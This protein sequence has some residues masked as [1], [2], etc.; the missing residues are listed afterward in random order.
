MQSGTNPIKVSGVDI[1]IFIA[2]FLTILAK[3]T[4]TCQLPGAF[5]LARLQCSQPHARVESSAFDE[6]G[7]GED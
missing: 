2:Q 6:A 3:L 7:S 4:E 5:T 1:E